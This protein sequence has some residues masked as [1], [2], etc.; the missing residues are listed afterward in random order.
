MGEASFRQLEHVALK[1]A[2]ETDGIIST[3]GGI[4][5]TPQNQTLL[6]KGYV[7]YLKTDLDVLCKRLDPTHRP[8]LHHE[9]LPIKLQQLLDER[10]QLYEQA[11]DLILDTSS[12]SCV[13][14]ST[15]ILNH[16][17]VVS[18]SLN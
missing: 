16:L 7:I 1:T 6:A 4:I 13:E 12:H 3:G 5:T 9:T 17:A 2:L 18:T 15:L 11:A 10:E 14:V 8:L